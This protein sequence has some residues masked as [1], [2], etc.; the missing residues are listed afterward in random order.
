MVTIDDWRQRANGP[1]RVIDNGVNGRVADNVE[2]FA[3]VLV[4]LFK[5]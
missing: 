5:R 3:Q 4:F 1:L 2:V